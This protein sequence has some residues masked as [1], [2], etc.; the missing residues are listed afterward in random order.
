MRRRAGSSLF[1]VALLAL[2]HFGLSPW[3][4]DRRVAPDFLFLALMVY[5]IRVRPGAAAVAGFS[6][7]ILRDSIAV[8]GFGAEALAHTVVGYLAAWGKAVFF[9]DNLIV[10]AGFFFAGVWLRDVLVLLGGGMPLGGIL[11]QFFFWSVL[12]ALTTAAAGVV[13]LLMFRNWLD[14]RISD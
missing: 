14:V 9:A 12:K 10:N 1:I 13:V 3:L 7:G 2:L 6:V 8:L 11:W 4:G 5:A